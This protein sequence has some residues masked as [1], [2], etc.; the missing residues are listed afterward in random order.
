MFLIAILMVLN[1]YVFQII[2]VALLTIL[3]ILTIMCEVC[4]IRNIIVYL[5]DEVVVVFIE[6]IY[7]LWCWWVFLKFYIRVLGFCF[8]VI[9]YV[10]ITGTHVLL[11]FNLI[12]FIQIYHTIF[13][14]IFPCYRFFSFFIYW[15]VIL[16]R[17]YNSFIIWISLTNSTI[18]LYITPQSLRTRYLNRMNKF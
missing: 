9:T 2:F 6:C 18:C 14:Y 4:F 13:F 15:P 17:N 3:T 1:C 5:M 10:F 16:T 11:I 7:Y 8:R 12:R